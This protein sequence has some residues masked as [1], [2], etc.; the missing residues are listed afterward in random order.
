MRRLG[1]AVVLG[2]A[3]TLGGQPVEARGAPDSFA[4]LSAHLLPT[5]VGIATPRR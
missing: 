2:V 4:D 3:L 1:F 5:V